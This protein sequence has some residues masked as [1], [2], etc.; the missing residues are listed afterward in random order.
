MLDVELYNM[1]VRTGLGVNLESRDKQE[2]DDV[3]ARACGAGREIE[4][5][6]RVGGRIGRGRVVAP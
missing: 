4:R 1:R 2:G 6:G 5:R 3:A